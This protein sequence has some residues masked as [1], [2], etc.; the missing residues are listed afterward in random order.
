MLKEKDIDHQRNDII[1]KEDALNVK[2][3]NFSEI[4]R[5]ILRTAR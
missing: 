4:K 5:K 2:D 1:T 3:V